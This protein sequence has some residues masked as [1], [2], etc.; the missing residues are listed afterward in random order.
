MT[1]KVM[2]GYVYGGG[3]DAEFVHSLE[4]CK[5]WDEKVGSGYLNHGAWKCANGGT[6]IPTQRNNIVQ[7]FLD[8]DCDW[9]WFVDTDETFDPDI[10]ER[11]V[12][13]ADPVERPIVSGLVMAYRPKHA[14]C[15]VEP[16]CAVLN[17]NNVL[18]TVRN[19]PAGNPWEVAAVGAGCLFVHRTVYE[20]VRVEAGDTAFP[21]FQNVSWH[22]PDANGDPVVAAMGEDYVFS[23][24]AGK[25]GFPILVDTDIQCGHRK[26][27]EFTANDFWA[28]VPFDIVEERTYVIVPVKDQRKLTESLLNQLAKQGG[29]AG[30][31]VLDNGSGKETRRYLERQTVAEVIPATGMGIHEMWNLGA[32]AALKRWPKCNLAF[33]NNDLNL[34]PDF[35]TGLAAALRGQEN[36]VAVS[37][38]YDNRP[39]DVL[40]PC[41]QIC[42][43]RYDG[44][45]GAPGFA[46]MVKGELFTYYAFP[47]DSKWWYGDNDL[48]MAIR[49]GGGIWAIT[50]DVTVEHIGGGGQ[51]GDWADYANTEQGQKDRQAF[52]A[53]WT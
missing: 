20:K 14:P 16:A 52:L 44:T 15:A 29:Y 12:T 8:T 38:N 30:I 51:T 49:A 5:L 23:L 39:L 28:Q 47:E 31:I 3:L 27:Y 50:P 45:G 33:L 19:I 13:S 41:D 42:A 2:V 34:G 35:L 37:P 43:D 7:T 36:L 11:L 22:R 10:I 1:V 48:L 17:D 24:R 9:L 32:K 46:F 26:T 4:R 18:M 40:L 25:A 21:W 6:S 53:R